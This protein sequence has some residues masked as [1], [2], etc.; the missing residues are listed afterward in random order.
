VK[1]KNEEI[2][3]K[4]TL[5]Q[6]EQ[7]ARGKKKSRGKGTEENWGKKNRGNESL[8]QLEGKEKKD[9]I[10]LPKGK[11]HGVGVIR[12]KVGRVGGLYDAE[13]L[14]KK[15]KKNTRGG[16]KRTIRDGGKQK[17]R[18]TRRRK[19]RKHGRVR[20]KT[21]QGTLPHDGRGNN[22]EKRGKKA[23]NRPRAKRHKSQGSK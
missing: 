8:E 4:G 6:S 19:N 9:E 7:S 17:K 11:K 20:K 23:Y 1:E 3:K 5:N 22:M 13:A 15:R 16:F 2:K 14:K 12:E 21:G 10:S 18:P